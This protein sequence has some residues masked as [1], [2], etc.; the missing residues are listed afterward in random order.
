MSKLCKTQL[1]ATVQ[2]AVSSVTSSCNTTDI[3]LNAYSADRIEPTNRVS[4]ALFAN[5]PD[6]NTFPNGYV[7]YL[8]DV[9]VPVISSNGVWIGIDG[10]MLGTFI[11]NQLLGFGSLTGDGTAT[12]RCSPVREFCLATDWCQIGTG[13]YHV[14]AVKSSGQLWSWGAN[15]CGRLGDGTTISRCSPI[16][17]ISSSLD[18]CQT[19]SSRAHNLAIKTSGQLWG[20]GAGGYGRLGNG[21][22][23]D[24]CSPVQEICSATD[25]CQA[26][27]GSNHSAAIKTSGEL[28]SWGSGC[29]GSLG[30]GTIST[31][32]SPIRE[33]CSAT[34]WC[35]V[36][37]GENNTVTVKTS[38]EL[39]AWGR[40]TCGVLGIGSVTC[41]CSPVREFYSATDW[42]QVSLNSFHTAAIKTSS[43]LWS[44]GI[45]F[46][47]R[48]GDGT[49]FNK[50]SPVREI[51]SA[52]DWCRVSVGCDHT[53]ALKTSGQLWAWG[54]NQC[55]NLGDGTIICRCSPIREISSS[56]T[57]CYISSGF[58]RS[59]A[60]KIENAICR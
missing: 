17:E 59:F 13:G 28:W 15:S 19:S 23:S 40:N 47:G 46:A 52:T 35:Q 32:C 26:S 58:C 3:L 55:G 57:W 53:I 22:V 36:S 5:L 41:Y 56:T 11:D 21:A 33:L 50:C 10:R 34:N 44:W 9:N 16:R 43:E 37:T 24:R 2:N 48:L 12:S 18:W 39:W 31:S 4:T 27:T 45:N 1:C 38:G 60:I 20:W 8:E 29:Y 6:A 7:V 42:C 25:W 51:C 30:N 54:N 49:T 14:T